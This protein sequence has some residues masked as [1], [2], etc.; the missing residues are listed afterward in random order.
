MT[1]WRQ[2]QFSTTLQQTEYFEA[3]EDIEIAS[4]AILTYVIRK[5]FDL[6]MPVLKWLISKQASLGRF[7]TCRKMPLEKQQC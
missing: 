4:Y 2:R 1:F 6:I 7:S 3:P 5:E